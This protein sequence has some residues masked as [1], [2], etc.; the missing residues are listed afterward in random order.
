VLDV[1]RDNVAMVLGH[2]SAESIDTD[3]AFRELGFD[4]LTAVELRNRLSTAIG[5]RLP[6]TL[7]FDHPT[8]AELAARLLA[9][10]RPDTA[11]PQEQARAELDRLDALLSAAQEAGRLTITTRLRSLLSKWDTTRNEPA[12]TGQEI[13]SATAAEI[14]GI[15]DQELGQ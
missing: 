2:N 9:E 5:Q 15:L 11:T 3:K 12:A 14:F 10:L 8:S 6:A 7:V 4:S 13:Q 1:V